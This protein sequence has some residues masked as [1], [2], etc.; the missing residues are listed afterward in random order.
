MNRVVREV[1][2][3]EKIDILNFSQQYPWVLSYPV[4]LKKRFLSEFVSTNKLIFD[5][6]D[7]DGRLASAVLLDKVNNVSND[8]CLEI[9]GMREGVDPTPL[10]AQFIELSKERSPL[11]RAG[12]QF[13]IDENSEITEDFLQKRGLAYHYA[14]FNMQ[15]KS[16]KESSQKKN[17]NISFALSS[18]AHSVYKVLCESFSQNLDT[19]IPDFD[20]WRPKFLRSPGSHFFLW[21]EQSEIMGFANLVEPENGESC[22]IKIIGVLP[23]HRERGIGDSLL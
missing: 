7:N 22:E 15:K 1:R 16:M 8:A 18:D 14:T 10:V 2:D 23:Q 9:L 4:A 17:P 3:I 21:K 13:A 19:S 11:H 20:V 5:I 12:F 6:H